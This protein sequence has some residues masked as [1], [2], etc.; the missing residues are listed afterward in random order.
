MT[1]VV[2]ITANWMNRCYFI[3]TENGTQTF[4]AHELNRELHHLTTR[5]SQEKRV[6]YAHEPLCVPMVF[7][8]IQRVIVTA[9][10]HGIC[11]TWEESPVKIE[12]FGDVKEI[13]AAEL[14]SF[15]EGEAP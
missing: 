6:I 4:A 10:A 7:P 14:Q 8:D 12:A 13:V 2:Y 11:F 15:F 1:A 9:N 3:T 5:L